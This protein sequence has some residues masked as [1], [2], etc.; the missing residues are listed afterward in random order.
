MAPT[1]HYSLDNGYANYHALLANL[2]KRFSNL[3]NTIV[4][5]TWSKSLDN[6]SGMV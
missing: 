2:Q 4:S 3:M 1:W 6:S 5:Y